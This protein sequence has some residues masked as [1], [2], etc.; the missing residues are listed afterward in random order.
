[1]KIATLLVTT[2]LVTLTAAAAGGAFALLALVARALRSSDSYVDVGLDLVDVDD[3]PNR[4][5]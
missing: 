3:A 5:D 4:C 2:L 1:M